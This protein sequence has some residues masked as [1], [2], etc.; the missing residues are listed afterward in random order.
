MRASTSRQVRT[1]ALLVL[2]VLLAGVGTFVAVDVATDDDRPTP[3]TSTSMS[4]SSPALALLP[5]ELPAPDT[6]GPDFVLRPPG[7]EPY[8]CGVV[9]PDEPEPA[10][11]S[12]AGYLSEPAAELARVELL[13]YRHDEDAAG[14]FA[15]IAA[16]ASCPGSELADGRPRSIAVDGADEAFTVDQADPEGSAGVA[17]GRVGS[18]LLIAEVDF[19]PTGTTD[20]VGSNDLLARAVSTLVRYREDHATAF[21]PPANL[22]PGAGSLESAQVAIRWACPR[23]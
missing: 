18:Q 4:T 13:T 19:H 17:V 9:V 2:A 10:G 5:Q 21:A 15:A 14:A 1:T 16:R 3:S 7:A 23:F 11:R 20:G 8:V 22:E 6:L 12:G